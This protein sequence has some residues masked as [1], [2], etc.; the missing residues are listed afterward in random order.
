MK[1]KPTYYGILPANVR[2]DKKLVPMA[3]ILYSE[4]TCLSNKNGECFAGNE[5][6]AELYEVEA[7]TVSRWV[8]S[9]V[10][11]GYLKRRFTYRAGTKEIKNRYLQINQEVGA[12]MT[13]GSM[14]KSQEGIDEKVKDNSTSINNTS[15]NTTDPQLKEKFEMIRSS[16]KSLLKG[17][18]RG[19]DTEWDNFSK[20]NTS[21]LQLLE[22]IF[23][24]AS[25]MY[26]EKKKE[27]DK[28]ETDGSKGNSPFTYT[29][30]FSTFIN[31]RKW[32]EYL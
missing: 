2:Y 17:K 5:Y 11:G 26:K 1:E 15:G 27:N 22:E 28:W 19:L 4:V 8:S 14:Q 25:N 10:K 9:L 3:R 21:T 29:P 13:R 20:K 6:F 32:E 30:N 12:K 23:N 16:Y 31:Q 7:T 24:G 18:A